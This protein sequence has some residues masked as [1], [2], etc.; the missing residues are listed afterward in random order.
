MVRVSSFSVII[1]FGDALLYLDFNLRPGPARR[2]AELHRLRERAGSDT[3][4]EDRA[5]QTDAAL[6]S[7]GSKACTT[8]STSGLLAEVTMMA[9]RDGLAGLEVFLAGRFMRT[10]VRRRA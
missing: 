4:V 5:P 1:T 3:L 2:G 8:R 7:S 6:D 9:S 10:I